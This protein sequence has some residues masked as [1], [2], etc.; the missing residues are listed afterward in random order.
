MKKISIVLGVSILLLS[1][2]GGNKLDLDEEKVQSATA[3][4]AAGQKVIEENNYKEEDIQVLKVC[5]AVKQGEEDY[6][7]NG[8]YIVY[9]QTNDGEY[10]RDFSMTSDYEIGYGS[11]R[12][13]EIEDRCIT[14]D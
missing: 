12:L 4:E 7:F 2:C 11:Q 6:G 3:E 8:E 10:K 5:E 9:W 13:E 1:A 14:L